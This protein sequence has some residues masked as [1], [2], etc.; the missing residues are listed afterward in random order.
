MQESITWL[1]DGPEKIIEKI[2]SVVEKGVLRRKQAEGEGL[3]GSAV[4]FAK[5]NP[6]STAG[7]VGAGGAGLASLL[8]SA[9]QDEE[10]RNTMSDLGTSALAGGA[11]GLGGYGAYKGLSNL[12]S[13]NPQ[14]PDWLKPLIGGTTEYPNPSGQGMLTPDQVANSPAAMDTLNSEINR[15]GALETVAGAAGGA[16]QGGAGLLNSAL[17]T[18]VNPYLN[19]LGIGNSTFRSPVDGQLIQIEKMPDGTNRLHFNLANG[20]KGHWI[21]A[22]AGQDISVDVGQNV[23]KGDMLSS[24]QGPESSPLGWA[25]VPNHMRLLAQSAASRMGIN[26]VDPYQLKEYLNR[27]GEKGEAPKRLFGLLGPKQPG[28][29]SSAITALQG[30]DVDELQKMMLQARQNPNASINYQPPGP[31]GKLPAPISL[32]G[33]ELSNLAH[34][35]GVRPGIADAMRGIGERLGVVKPKGNTVGATGYSLTPARNIPAQPA[36]HIFGKPIPAKTIPAQVTPSPGRFGG[37]LRR[38]PTAGKLF[39][40][41]SLVAPTLVDYA[42]TRGGVAQPSQRS[43]DVLNRLVKPQ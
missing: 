9:S 4:N 16:A 41:A 40:A 33:K 25:S 2:A 32:R 31:E 27:F 17:R 3:W 24:S 6:W 26:G 37:M 18:H 12:M 1:N 21:N 14:V 13:G 11:L 7:L 42:M 29:P 10:D 36:P 38:A 22:P 35:A 8:N 43:L 28:I 20:E 23:T 19:M 34:Q 5:E 39:N 30:A 15:P